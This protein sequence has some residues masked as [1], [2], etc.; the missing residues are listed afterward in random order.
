MDFA[1]EYAR[2]HEVLDAIEHEQ[3][4]NEEVSTPPELK[5]RGQR[6]L[7]AQYAL[8]ILCARYNDHERAIEHFHAVL[9]WIDAH[10]EDSDDPD[11][12]ETLRMVLGDLRLNVQTNLATLL[13]R[14]GDASSAMRQLLDAKQALRARNETETD[15]PAE[16][17]QTQ[18]LVGLEVTLNANNAVLLH[19]H[20]RNDDA[21]HA[22]QAALDRNGD[23]NTVNAAQATAHSV[24][25]SC[26]GQS[27]DAQKARDHARQALTCLGTSSND[28]NQYA[29]LLNNVAVHAV[30]ADNASTGLAHVLTAYRS[31]RDHP[32]A[33]DTTLQ[34]TL[35][36]HLGT[37]LAL[38]DTTA[39]LE[40]K[41][42]DIKQENET[43][44]AAAC[45]E[46]TTQLLQVHPDATLAILTHAAQGQLA[47]HRNDPATT[48]RELT[49]ALTLLEQLPD[50]NKDESIKLQGV[51]ESLLG[52][53][54]LLLGN[55]EQA[56]A[57][58]QRD[59]ELALDTEDLH[60]QLRALRNLALLYNTTQR[61]D[62]A[63][64]L[65]RESVEIATVAPSKYELMLAYGGLGAA[66]RALQLQDAQKNE[67]QE[68]LAQ[69]ENHPRAIFI[70]QRTLA[71]ELGD[72]EQQV[73]AQRA[74]VH[75]YEAPLSSFESQ[76]L[77]KRLEECDLF[78]HFA[79]PYSQSVHQADAYRALANAL[80]AQLTRLAERGQR[81]AD[82]IFVLTQKR[83]DVA[84]KYLATTRQ[85]ESEEGQAPVK[86]PASRPDVLFR[87]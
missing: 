84:R 64:P 59:L 2:L 67:F 79:E 63:I 5:C 28:A 51:L 12:D 11:V 62:E 4:A 27:G 81:F 15:T 68:F 87:R 56:E 1:T 8:G 18:A 52:C 3:D 20:D 65:W 19:T 37:L 22:A 21:I 54:Q 30:E 71:M 29:R 75:T 55:T 74:L 83:D 33:S 9:T 57:T 77:E 23:D 35:T 36:Y 70:K 31:I 42:D 34:A 45:F 10:S 60:A 49:V 44:D 50:A 47:Y 41:S 82:A 85:M 16:T 17:T 86:R 61:F 48:E 39:T 25:S 6:V 69:K 14:G 53:A 38:L 46:L 73:M 24:L 72:A 80:T 66:L 40:P 13:F 7:E 43:V 32:E 58:L 78:V 76:E 26:Y